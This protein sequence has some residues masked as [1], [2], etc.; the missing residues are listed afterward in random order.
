METIVKKGDA[1]PRIMLNGDKSCLFCSKVFSD[2][3][4]CRKHMLRHGQKKG[5]ECEICHQLFQGR[6]LMLQHMMFEHK[7]QKYEYKCDICDLVFMDMDK[8][9]EHTSELHQ[10]EIQCVICYENFLTNEDLT[11]HMADHV[12]NKTALVCDL[13]GKYYRSRYNLNVHMKSHTGEKPFECSHCDQAFARRMYLFRHIET[14]HT[15]HMPYHCALCDVSFK[16]ILQLR[17]HVKRKVHQ[18][19]QNNENPKN[20]T[21]DKNYVCPHCSKTFAQQTYLTIHLRTHSTKKKYFCPICSRGFAQVGNMRLHIQRIH[22]PK[23]HP[24]LIKNREVFTCD[25]CQEE[26]YTKRSLCH[27][28]T[29]RHKPKPDLNCKICHKTFSDQPR[30][31]MHELTHDKDASIK[32]KSCNK[33]FFSTSNLSRHHKTCAFFLQGVQFSESSSTVVKEEIVTEEIVTSNGNQVIE[34]EQLKDVLSCVIKI[35]PAP[36]HEYVEI[37]QQD[38]NIAQQINLDDYTETE[39]SY[40]Y[41]E[42]TDENENQNQEVIFKEDYEDVIDERETAISYSLTNQSDHQIHNLNEMIQSEQFKQ[43]ITS[44][45]LF[46]PATQES[47]PGSESTESAINNLTYDTLTENN[48][49]ENIQSGLTIENSHDESVQSHITEEYDHGGNIQPDLTIVNNQSESVQSDLTI[50]NNHDEDIQSDLTIENNQE[51]DIQSDL[52]LENNQGEDI[53]SDL[54]LE[55]NQGEDIQSDL[56]LENNRAEDIQSD[57]PLE[58]NQGEDIQSDLPLENNQ[59]EDIQS[60]LP[61]E[62]NRAEDIQS[63]LPLENNQ[64]EDIQ[65]DLPLENSH[66]EDIQSDLTIENNQIEDIQSDLT[67]DD[68]HAEYIQ[69]DLT[70]NNSCVE[71]RQSQQVELNDVISINDFEGLKVVPEMDDWSNNAHQIIVYKMDDNIVEISYVYQQ[72]PNEPIVEEEVTTT[73][74]E[75]NGEH[76]VT[77]ETDIQQNAE[78]ASSDVISALVDQ[79]THAVPIDIVEVKDQLAINDPGVKTNFRKGKATKRSR[80]LSSGRHVCTACGKEF[81]NKSNLNHH[82][83]RHDQ[84]KSNECSICKRLFQGRQQVFQHKILEHGLK[85]TYFSCNICQSEVTTE[86]EL[87]QHQTD[88]HAEEYPYECP[89]CFRRYQNSEEYNL[90]VSFHAKPYKCQMCDKGY[91]TQNSLSTHLRFHEENKKYQCDVCGKSFGASCHLKAHS[92]THHDQKPFTCQTCGRGYKRSKD[93]EKHMK[94]HERATKS[95]GKSKTKK[96][97]KLYKCSVCNKIFNQ[98]TYLTVHMRTHTR[99]HPYFCPICGKTFVQ[100]GNMQKHVRAHSKPKKPTDWLKC[101]ECVEVFRSMAELNKH[102]KF[103]HSDGCSTFICQTCFKV[104]NTSRSLDLHMASHEDFE[105]VECEVCHKYFRNKLALEKH[106]LV[107]VGPGVRCPICNIKCCGDQVLKGHIERQHN[108]ENDFECSVCQRR[109]PNQDKLD[110]HLKTHRNKPHKCTICDKSYYDPKTLKEHIEMHGAK[111]EYQ[112]DVC[113]KMFINRSRLR[114]HVK[115]HIRKNEIIN[116][117][118]ELNGFGNVH[119]SKP[120]SP[121]VHKS[122][123]KPSIKIFISSDSFEC[124]DC[125]QTFMD[126]QSFL[127]HVKLHKLAKPTPLDP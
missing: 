42:P 29:K 55:N 121:M 11:R 34:D 25:V 112:C 20:E 5:N 89:K 81:A 83:R 91:D 79:S 87:R 67:K 63:D 26:F 115:I 60:D 73:I 126:N 125:K 108:P 16:T 101:D 57:L 44:I 113:S 92:F 56:P 100:N 37:P 68:N 24:K 107:H 117:R 17:N 106:K 65:S 120:F 45:I 36:D 9:H 4:N 93:L 82:E 99:E 75:S 61:L 10:I 72:T 23:I 58:N 97:D 122:T 18:Q 41:A 103:Q 84:N 77:M 46:D 105:N 116:D 15:A 22:K 71:N 62:N 123:N 64:E 94:T 49:S 78:I 119:K 14:K 48:Y 70:T 85:P 6:Q 86:D 35:E 39:E 2:Y 104:F 95:A 90:H 127:E 8:L 76:N 66:D 19:N 40:N 43:N 88:V 54:P 52:P 96:T 31:R 28:Q 27:H 59:G 32:C 47:L 38:N 21:L 114:R 30:L 110:M 33:T 102:K 74:L 80:K 69:S 13:C 118:A 7:D 98:Q 124:V 51:E 53:Q 109:Y 1:R 12:N 3:S 50:A 111:R